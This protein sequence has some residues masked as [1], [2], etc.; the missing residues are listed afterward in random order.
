M[1]SL[2]SK[3][4][5]HTN[6]QE[7]KNPQNIRILEKLIK[8]YNIRISIYFPL[9]NFLSKFSNSLSATKKIK[10]DRTNNIKETNKRKK[11]FLCYNNL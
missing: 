3:N 9:F 7:Y 11:F 2:F 8:I 6:L 4:N 5:K 10:I 1:F